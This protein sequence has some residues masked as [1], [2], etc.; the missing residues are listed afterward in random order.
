MRILKHL[1]IAL[2]V[3]AVVFVI[4]IVTAW[5]RLRGEPT[6]YPRQWMTQKSLRFFAIDLDQYIEE[7]KQENQRLPDR[8]ADLPQFSPDASF[9][10]LTRSANGDFLDEWKNPIQYQAMEDKFVI[11][12]LGRD[13]AAGGVGPD[14]DL[15][16]DD[17]NRIA[18]ASSFYQFLTERDSSE[19][20][21]QGF[22]FDGIV[23][24]AIVALTIFLKLLVQSKNREKMKLRDTVI[25]IVVIVALTVGVGI[26]LLPLHIP[27]GH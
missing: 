8:L 9:A 21:T 4:V 2:G 20:A 12:S 16:S 13:G 22:F 23:T 1:A 25:G 24:A 26:V 10:Y 6:L 11:M 27:S 3:A 5:S 18:R 15:Y 14:A 7:Y 19:I 17:R